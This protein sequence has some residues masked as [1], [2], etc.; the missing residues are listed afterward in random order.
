METTSQWIP[1]MPGY[2]YNWIAPLQSWGV[3]WVPIKDTYSPPQMDASVKWIHLSIPEGVHIL[4][5]LGDGAMHLDKLAGRI[6]A[7]YIYYRQDLGKLEI[8]AEDITSAMT[9]ASIYLNGLK[10]TKKIVKLI[11]PSL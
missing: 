7:K 11:P 6:D 10:K 5:L 1:E 4:P 2:Y 9:Q 8:W 3:R